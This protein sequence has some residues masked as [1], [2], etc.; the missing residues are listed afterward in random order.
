[1][2][3]DLWFSPPE[4]VEPIREF[5]DGTIHYDPC[6]CIKANETIKAA[7][8]SGED[9]PYNPLLWVGSIWLNPPYCNGA[10]KL[11]LTRA[12]SNY[13]S[14]DGCNQIIALVNR[15]DANWYHNFIDSHGFAYYQFRNRIKFI[16][17]MRGK[18]SAPRYNNDLFY[19]GKN[20]KGFF[21]L[22]IKKFGKPSPIS[23]HT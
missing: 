21:E 10:M 5:F 13:L 8:F 18:T 9:D 3:H 2:A 6:S 14:V 23:F 1:M 7:N 16:D 11:W 17:G 20:S 12:R 4:I 22:C 15:S 19:W